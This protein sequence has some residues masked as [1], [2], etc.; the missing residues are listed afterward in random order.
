MKFMAPYAFASGA[1][2]FHG[3]P[4]VRRYVVDMCRRE[5]RR[6][7]PRS[8]SFMNLTGDCARNVWVSIRSGHVRGNISLNV[9]PFASVSLVSS[10]RPLVVGPG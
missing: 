10:T 1:Y 9:A 8:H 6:L 5:R 7:T 4:D 3:S 2:F